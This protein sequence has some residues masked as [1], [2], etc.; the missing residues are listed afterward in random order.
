MIQI[1]VKAEFHLVFHIFPSVCHSMPQYASVC[2]SMPYVIAE[3]F[4]DL[5][6]MSKSDSQQYQQLSLS[7]YQNNERY[8]ISYYFS[9]YLYNEIYYLLLSLCISV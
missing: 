5:L 9:A 1:F 8:I 7:A 2:L 4:I 6:S 3:S